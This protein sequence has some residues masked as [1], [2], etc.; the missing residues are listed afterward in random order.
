MV[1]HWFAV[2][3][4]RVEGQVVNYTVLKGCAILVFI[5]SQVRLSNL[6]RSL[7]EPALQVILEFEQ[8]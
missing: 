8:Y 4:N 5:R 3:G 1:S 6:H 7:P 2:R